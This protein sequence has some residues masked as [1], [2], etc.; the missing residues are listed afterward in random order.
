MNI[1]GD[2]QLYRCWL[3]IKRAILARDSIKLSKKLMAKKGKYFNDIWR[4]LSWVRMSGEVQ[5]SSRKDFWGTRRAMGISPSFLA[6]CKMHKTLDTKWRQ[7]ESLQICFV[8]P[9]PCLLVIWEEGPWSV[10]TVTDLTERSHSLCS[11]VA[12]L[13]HLHSKQPGWS[14]CSL[15]KAEGNTHW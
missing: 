11:S 14:R 12:S 1:P 6:H 15:R 7:K 5:C 8:I 10:W 13:Q 4:T 9:V 2:Q 3:C